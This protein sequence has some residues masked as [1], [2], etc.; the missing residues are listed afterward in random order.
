MDL[1]EPVECVLQENYSPGLLPDF[2]E[3]DTLAP[4]LYAILSLR[5]HR[6]APASPVDE[7]YFLKAVTSSCVPFPVVVLFPRFPCSPENLV[8]GSTVPDSLPRPYDRL[9]GR[10]VTW[11]WPGLSTLRFR[12]R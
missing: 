3:S 12:R 10:S 1:A 2:R 5:A 8:S 4:D 11:M 9:V 6:F 7:W